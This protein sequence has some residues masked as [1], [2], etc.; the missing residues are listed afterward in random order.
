MEANGLVG[1]ISTDIHFDPANLEHSYR[2]AT[3]DAATMQTGL[4]IRETH[5]LP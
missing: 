1:S 5:C 4:A 3:A 2:V